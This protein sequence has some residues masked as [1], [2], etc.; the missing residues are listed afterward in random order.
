MIIRSL[1]LDALYL[2]SILAAILSE[3][4]LFPVGHVSFRQADLELQV[5]EF[6]KNQNSRLLRTC[7][8][9]LISFLFIPNIFQAQNCGL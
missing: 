7:L 2:A 5:E 9:V 3:K 6:L 8:I 4:N 1:E